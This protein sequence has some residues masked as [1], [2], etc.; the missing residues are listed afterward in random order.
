[1]TAVKDRL[2]KAP[3]P[4]SYRNL[5][6]VL[7][8]PLKAGNIGSAARAMKNMGLR[9]LKLVNPRSRFN[10]MECLKMAGKASD[11][12]AEAQIFPTFEEAVADENVLVGTTSAR[13]RKP[14]QRFYTPRQIAP[15][16]C[17]YTL[18]QRL[19]L[20]FGPE[21]Q[22]LTDAQLAQ[23]QYLVFVPANTDYPVLNVAQ[24]VMILAYEIFNVE[25]VNLNEHLELVPS[26][27]REA[28]FEHMRKVLLEIGFLH[29]ENPEAIMRSIR[30][31]LGRADLT[32]RDVQ[33]I[34][35]IMSHVEWYVTR[36]SSQQ[37]PKA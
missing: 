23:C 12:I 29:K 28:M 33:I 35:G 7:V 20:V 30:R 17:E 32:A 36:L 8:Q 26:E 5:S 19:A 14:R 31:F 34:R 27:R 15:I 10:N 22:G 4:K 24:S 21:D 6:V 13:D 9:K 37:L 16:V 2:P 1:M 11:L 25:D 3:P 18:N